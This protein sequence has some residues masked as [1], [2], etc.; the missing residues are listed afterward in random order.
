MILDPR[1]D[2]H[3][4]MRDGLV[5]YDRRWRFNMQRRFNVQGRFNVHRRRISMELF[6]NRWR[7]RY[8]CDRFRF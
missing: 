3:G 8:D 1:D 2:R 7:R 6:N 5:V 4:R